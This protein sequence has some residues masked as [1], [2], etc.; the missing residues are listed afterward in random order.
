M[1]VKAL[2]L[3][4]VVRVARLIADFSLHSSLCATAAPSHVESHT[5]VCSALY[6]AHDQHIHAVGEIV[7]APVK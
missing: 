3:T 6:I 2:P 1:H 7:C 4:E 5:R